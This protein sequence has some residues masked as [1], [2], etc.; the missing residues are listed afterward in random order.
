[1]TNS[2]KSGNFQILHYLLPHI[3]N[4][5]IF[6]QPKI[7]NISILHTNRNNNFIPLRFYFRF[8]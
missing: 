7:Q 8:F 5:V 4:I 6:V 2:D 3:E 1:M